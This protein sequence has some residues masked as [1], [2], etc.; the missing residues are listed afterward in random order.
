MTN[1]ETHDNNFKERVLKDIAEEDIKVYSRTHFLVR[2][3][4]LIA[5]TILTLIVSI[6]IFNYVFFSLRISGHESLL[7]FGP[8]GIVSFLAF[9][10]WTLLLTD[11]VLI[12]I[13]EWL[14][15]KFRFGY[16]SPV[17]YLL[18]GLL[19]ITISSGYLIDRETGFND[20]LLQRADH[21]YLPG[22]FG[23]IYENARGSSLLEQGLCKCTITAINGRILVAQDVDMDNPGATT[24]VTILTSP[25][26]IGMNSLKV[27]DTI[28]VAGTVGPTD[29]IQAFGISSPL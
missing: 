14:L 16:R 4:L 22:P 1:N 21:D 27:G 20:V 3:I 17:L 2:V 13:L 18:L 6:F 5:T 23:E 9:F 10:P 28:F 29:T 7:Y 8:R 26:Y 12:G 15:R 25:D 19:A 24:T 11:I